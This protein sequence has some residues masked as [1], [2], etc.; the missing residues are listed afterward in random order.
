MASL[1]FAECISG[2]EA[3]PENLGEDKCSEKTAEF[4]ANYT[5]MVGE[6]ERCF[7]S[8]DFILAGAILDCPVLAEL[9]AAEDMQIDICTEVDTSCQVDT[10]ISF[11][12]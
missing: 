11:G 10:E 4:F 3:H 5:V 8:T 7:T 6:L 1:E 12:I 9:Y 2:F